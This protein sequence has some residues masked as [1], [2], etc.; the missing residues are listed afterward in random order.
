MIIIGFS[1]FLMV[2]SFFLKKEAG[3]AL[4]F[5]SLGV[6]MSFIVNILDSKKESVKK[7]KEKKIACKNANMIHDP[8]T[9]GYK[10]SICDFPHK[11]CSSEVY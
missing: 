10:C 9:A 4:F 7:N 6:I 3:L 8:L 5:F 1:A 11:E 2:I